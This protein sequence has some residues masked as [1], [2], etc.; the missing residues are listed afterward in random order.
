M[1]PIRWL[2]G[3]AIGVAFVVSL[4][5]GLGIQRPGAHA[6][7][8]SDPHAACRTR[9]VAWGM[10]QGA[11]DSL[12]VTDASSALC[13]RAQRIADA[14]EL[15]P[16][17]LSGP[18]P[19]AVGFEAVDAPVRTALGGNLPPRLCVECTDAQRTS[20]Y[21]IR[22]TLYD[23]VRSL[24]SDRVAWLTTTDAPLATIADAA[25]LP[26]HL[27]LEAAWNASRCEHAAARALAS[28]CTALRQRS[29]AEVDR[30]V[31]IAARER[32]RLGNCGLDGPAT[33][34]DLVEPAESNHGVWR[35][36]FDRQSATN[37]PHPEGP[38]VVYANPSVEED[39]IL[40]A[41][42][43]VALRRAVAARLRALGLPI[44]SDRA[45]D[46][47]E[48]AA[49]TRRWG[50]GGRCRESTSGRA[51]EAAIR[52][53]S[54][55]HVQAQCGATRQTIL[56]CEFSRPAPSHCASTCTLSVAWDDPLQ[57]FHQWFIPFDAFT[58]L[59]P[60]TSAAANLSADSVERVQRQYGGYYG[61]GPISGLGS[62]I[63]P[64]R[65]RTSIGELDDAGLA[66][67]L[68][69]SYD[70]LRA[71]GGQAALNVRALAEI[72]ADRR[73]TRVEVA[74]SSLE[75]IEPGARACLTRALQRTIFL[76]P[77]PAPGRAWFSFDVHGRWSRADRSASNAALG[78]RYGDAR[79]RRVGIGWNDLA[80]EWNW[81]DRLE[82]LVAACVDQLDEV[83]PNTPVRI[84][85]RVSARGTLSAPRVTSSSSQLAACVQS[86]LRNVRLGCPFVP[87]TRVELAMCVSAAE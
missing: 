4:Y 72:G 55:A 6:Q 33:A 19:P 16:A 36:Y 23:H 29:A 14:M 12:E 20:F 11:A 58:D 35:A 40:F 74:V 60:W 50:P 13:Q 73:A 47:I 10:S 68:D 34:A 83:A 21:A 26:L 82:P 63:V 51:F 44:A 49:L 84:E 71:C 25:D 17:A 86:R 66:A 52:G 30:I 43:R 41:D 54:T 56:D 7:P 77:I 69:G 87:D 22:A 75:S 57:G 59:A 64:G 79:I 62:A 65:L 45:S 70:A 38:Y 1:R 31:G 32:S 48:A 46:A 42:E 39:S 5:A 37:V 53:R 15:N 8:A 18:F 78:E 85:A 81:P 67:T 61:F 3:V 27:G 2:C 9:M 76:A 24:L 80:L 28:H